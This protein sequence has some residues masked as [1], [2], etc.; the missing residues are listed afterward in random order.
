MQG[1][2]V[3][4]IRNKI[5]AYPIKEWKKEFNIASKIKIYLMEWTIDS[6][7][8]FENALVDKKQ[9]DA[10]IYLKKK[11]NITINSVTA[12]FFME[13]Y[14][15]KN[16]ELKNNQLFNFFL[17]MCFLNKIKIIVI[18]MVDK[19]SL[20]KSFKYV[21]GIINK[22]NQLQPILKKYKLKIAFEVDL[23]PIDCLHFINHFD[24]KYFGINYDIGNS[25]G[26]NFNYKDE[27]NAYGKRIINVHIKNKKKNKTCDLFKGDGNIKKIISFLKQ[28]KYNK[29]YIL[30]TARVTKNHSNKIKQYLDT[31]KKF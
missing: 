4:V 29:N 13:K 12:D 26:N 28:N 8:F 18:P 10:I 16:F 24:K 3:S 6:Y 23:N 17:K 14:N 1:R 2:L 27:I 25:I 15:L 5:Q 30:Q 20:N 7:N 21:N 22:F 19:C 31:I 11:Y 9:H